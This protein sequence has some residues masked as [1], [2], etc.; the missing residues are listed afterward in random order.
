MASYLDQRM[1]EDRQ[2]EDY[3]SEDD[4]VDFGGM[5][6]HLLNCVLL[7]INEGSRN[8]DTKL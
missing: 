4:E 1:V 6:V 5:N 2:R 7:T 8:L 3:I